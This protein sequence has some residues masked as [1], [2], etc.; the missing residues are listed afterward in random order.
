MP[1]VILLADSFDER[2]AMISKRCDHW[3]NVYD[4]VDVPNGSTALLEER[5]DKG[6]TLFDAALQLESARSWFIA[7]SSV[8]CLPECIT[9]QATEVVVTQPRELRY[10]RTRCPSCV[11]FQK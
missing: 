7:C 4:G 9:E 5:C 10:I 1:R 11:I 6:H 3:V 2:H 8:L